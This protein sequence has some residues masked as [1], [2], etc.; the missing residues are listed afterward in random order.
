MDV[1]F[2]A[3]LSRSSSNRSSFYLTKLRNERTNNLKKKEKKM[4]KIK[5]KLIKI[6]QRVIKVGARR[7]S[8]NGSSLAAP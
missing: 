3:G 5:K 8:R 6:L 4:R 1:I 7:A 2:A